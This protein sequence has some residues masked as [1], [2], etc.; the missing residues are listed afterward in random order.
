MG[1]PAELRNRIYH[2]TFEDSLVDIP[3]RRKPNT[4]GRLE[5][6]GLLVSCKQAYAEAVSIYYSTVTFEILNLHGKGY[7][8]RLPKFLEYIGQEKRAL[9]QSI[10]VGY[11][12]SSPMWS[13]AL[14][15]VEGF[16]LTGI[17]I[18]QSIH[19]DQAYKDCRAKQV[20]L[21]EGVIKAGLSLPD[22]HGGSETFWTS[23]PEK[24][25]KDFLARRAKRD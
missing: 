11:A 6:P 5:A 16:V 18:T 23:E 7:T 20:V 17:Y 9:I 24:I 1:L 3:A 2:Y 21:K 13:L 22:D 25:G 14:W 8:N 4:K 19:L 12:T 10:R 15:N